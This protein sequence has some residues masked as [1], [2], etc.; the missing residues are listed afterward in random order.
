MHIFV[1]TNNTI[2]FSP[3]TPK[4][5]PF[6]RPPWR[7]G[8]ARYFITDFFPIFYKIMFLVLISM[9]YS[10]CEWYSSLMSYNLVDYNKVL[11]WKA[12]DGQNYK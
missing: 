6:G 7:P 8:R 1:Y 11:F 4:F 12:I 5:T 3:G 2:F 10:Y 9:L